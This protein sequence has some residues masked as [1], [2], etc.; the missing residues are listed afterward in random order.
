MFGLPLVPRTLGVTS[1]PSL[2]WV[3]GLLHRCGG[4][5]GGRHCQVKDTPVSEEGPL[6]DIR[7]GGVKRNKSM[8]SMFHCSSLIPFWVF[9]AFPHGVWIIP[10]GGG[11]HAPCCWM[12]GGSGPCRH[13]GPVPTTPIRLAPGRTGRCVSKGRSGGSAPQPE[14]TAIRRGAHAAGRIGGGRRTPPFCLL[15][16]PHL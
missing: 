13:P 4:G 6:G 9:A 2:H 14:V 12:T 10:G 8:S 11:V 1:P 7:K 15:M 3:C 16:C 5:G